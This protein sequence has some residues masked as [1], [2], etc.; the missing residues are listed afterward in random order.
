MLHLRSFTGF[1]IHLER[2]NAFRLGQSIKLRKVWVLWRS[3]RGRPESTSQGRPLNVRL[4]RPLD[5]ISG[6]PQDVRLGRPRDGQIGSLGDV[7]G[8]RP[9]DVLGTNICR[10]GRFW[11][12]FKKVQHFVHQNGKK[13]SNSFHKKILHAGIYRLS[14]IKNE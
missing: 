12:I 10:L 3:S 2:W 13:L 4:G 9:R 1:S 5:V 8:G 14:A 11:A 6:R 7:G